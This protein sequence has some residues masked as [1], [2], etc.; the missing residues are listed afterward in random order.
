VETHQ[1]RVLLLRAVT[2][3]LLAVLPAPLVEMV[4]QAV[5]EITEQQVVPA[6]P[7]VRVVQEL[8]Q[9]LTA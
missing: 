2:A 7:A 3:V 4:A 5:V 9:H 1:I 6:I 8:Q